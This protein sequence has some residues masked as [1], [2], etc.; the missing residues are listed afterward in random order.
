MNEQGRCGLATQC[1]D[2]FT[3]SF[4][5]VKNLNGCAGCLAPGIFCALNKKA[6]PFFPNTLRANSLKQIIVA[7]TVSLDVKT[8]IQER[9]TRSAFGAEKQCNQQPAQPTLPIA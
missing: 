7:L 8:Q 5:E 3:I 4:E 1:L 9:L 6:E 2:L